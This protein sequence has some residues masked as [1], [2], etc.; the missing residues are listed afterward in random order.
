MSSRYSNVMLTLIVLLLGAI[1]AKLY[2]PAAQ[3]IG[4][5]FAAPTRGEALAARRIPDPAQRKAAIDEL[6]SR[7]PSV[8]IEGGDVDV[9]GSDVTVSGE[10][11]VTPQ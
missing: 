8:W 2:V 3:Q 9:S 4:P 5:Q 10:V 6:R 7:A 11:T 1:V